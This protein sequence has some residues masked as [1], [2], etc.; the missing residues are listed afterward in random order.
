MALDQK[1]SRTFEEQLYVQARSW[2]G[3]IVQPAVVFFSAIGVSADLM[4]YIGL[5][6]VIL[7]AALMS[8]NVSLALVILAVALFADNLDGEIARYRGTASDKGKFTDVV[9]DNVTFTVFMF[10]MAYAG[11]V[12]GLLAGIVV[13]AMLLCRTFMVIKKNVTKETDWL[14]KVYAGFFPNFFVYVLYASFFI[15]ALGY[16][17]SVPA[18]TAISALAL[19][20]KA[21]LD[22]RTIKKTVFSR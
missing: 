19:S 17:N 1:P 18:M 14:I 21:L 11:F 5:G 22:F 12:S 9:V 3:T 16:G 4:S 6:L 7:S 20:L 2:R 10:G 13:Y 15:L 8:S